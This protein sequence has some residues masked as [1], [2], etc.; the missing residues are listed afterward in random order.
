MRQFYEK[1]Q[2]YFPATFF[3]GGFVF[4]LLTTDRIDQVFSLIQQAA[5]LALIML[6][7]YWEVVTPKAFQNEEK[8]LTKLWGWHVELLHFLF[9][10]LLSLYTIFYFKSASLMTSFAFMFFLAALLVINE[11]PQFQKRGFLIRSALLALCLSSYFI[12]LVPVMT[13]SIGTF[14]FVVA[15]ATS[16]AIFYLLGTRVQKKKQEQSWIQKNILLPG[17][18][19]QML[20]IGLYFFK[21]LPPV[22]ISLKHIG[23]Y[24]HVQRQGDSFALSYERPWWKFWQ[25]GAQSFHYREG[26]QVHCFVQ[27]FSPTQFSDAMKLVWYKRGTKGWS[28]RDAIG[29]AIRG[30]RDRGYRGHAYKSNFEKG[31]WQIRVMTS[32]EREVGRISFD[33]IPDTSTGDRDWRTDYH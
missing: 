30:G 33:V 27:I 6:F 5:Y 2:G 29:L 11:F 3:I 32:D 22:P 7:V 18:L 14:S 4:D 17:L 13:G 31:K 9:G 8:F 25:S 26:D 1:Y 10:S 12:Y 24:H 23:I 28:Q 20:L 19:V 15:M 21:A 16:M